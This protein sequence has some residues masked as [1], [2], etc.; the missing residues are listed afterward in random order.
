MPSAPSPTQTATINSIYY[1]TPTDHPKSHNRGRPATAGA[2][3]PGGF[4]LVQGP[5][6]LNWRWR[7]WGVLPRIENADLTPHNPPT[8]K[9][10]LRW[11]EL[12]I[13]VEGRPEW[14]FAKLHT[15]GGVPRNMD[16]LLGEPMRAFY[17]SLPQFAV[18]HPGFHYH[19]ATARELVNMVH[20]AEAGKAGNPSDYRDYRY[21]SQIH[22]PI[23]RPIT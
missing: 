2:P 19:Y 4:L 23:S 7:K 1:A 6:G 20:A 9:R 12:N 10:L 3:N 22:P 21:T 17:R 16:M 14:I 8:M 11:L 13:H 15:H 18:A 5:L